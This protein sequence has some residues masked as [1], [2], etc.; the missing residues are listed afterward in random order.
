MNKPNIVAEKIKNYLLNL[1]PFTSMS[2]LSKFQVIKYLNYGENLEIPIPKGKNK[3]KVIK[4]VEN[5]PSLKFKKFWPSFETTKNSENTEIFIQKIFSTA[6]KVLFLSEIQHSKAPNSKIICNNTFYNVLINS[7]Y[8]DHK[9]IIKGSL[10]STLTY[11]SIELNARRN[12]GAGALDTATFDI[13]NILT[14]NPELVKG[15]NR[16]KISELSDKI[17]DREFLPLEEEFKDRSRNELDLLILTILGFENPKEI[18]DEIYESLLIMT[19][20]R[21]KKANTFRKKGK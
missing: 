3:G 14:L 12:F 9:E 10:L 11:I 17:A 5:I 15:P 7:E 21:L 6:Y 8:A 2:D 20:E 19:N 16:Q 18:R 4:G 13:E 1:D